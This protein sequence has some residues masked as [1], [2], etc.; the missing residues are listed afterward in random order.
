MLGLETAL[1]IVLDFVRMGS[2]DDRRAIAALTGGP[3]KA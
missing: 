2:L 1:P 3:A